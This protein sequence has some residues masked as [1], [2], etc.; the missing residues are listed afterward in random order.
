MMSKM[1]LI[2]GK[3]QVKGIVEEIFGGDLHPKQRL[4]LGYAALGLLESESLIL[5]R[6]GQGFA[7]IRGIEKKHATKQI[8]RLLSNK[9]LNIWE[10]SGLWAKYLLSDSKEVIV[11]LD[12]SGVPSL[13]MNN[14]C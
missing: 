6:M 11:A 7:K 10:L 12:W 14:R 8:D 2:E 4:S 5:H 13:M 9:K 3:I 1:E